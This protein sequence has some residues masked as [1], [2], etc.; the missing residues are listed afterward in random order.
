MPSSPAPLILAS[1]SRTRRAV[2]E[3][4]GVAFTVHA[5][6]VD[7]SRHPG[8][9]PEDLARRLAQ[10]KA[11]AVAARYPRHLIIGADQVAAVGGQVFGKPG[12]AATATHQLGRLSGQ[13]VVY[14]SAV[15]V[16]DTRRDRA[17][18]LLV[19]DRVRLRA[20]DSAA[21]ERYVAADRPFDCAGSLRSE[22]LG[23][24][25]CEEILSTDPTSLLGLP[26][27][28]L[29]GILRTLGYALP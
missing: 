22:G 11:R 29:T 19:E 7:E 27:I 14:S 24:A 4:L 13:T 18:E 9:A 16:L 17:H 5:A 8:E 28:G 12:D 2:L 25:L 21:I 20:L 3:R 6:D 10:D 23:I 26:L 15:C 1:G